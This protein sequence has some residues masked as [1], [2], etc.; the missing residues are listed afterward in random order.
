M[1]TQ[2]VHKNNMERML[3][4][5]GAVTGGIGA[6]VLCMVKNVLTVNYVNHSEVINAMIIAIIGGVTGWMVQRILEVMFKAK[7]EH[8]LNKIKSIKKPKIKK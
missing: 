5:L 4:Y 7:F 8:L 6:T 1:L 3:N 2:N